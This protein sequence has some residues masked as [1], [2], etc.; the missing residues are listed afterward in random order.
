[1][2][3]DHAH[4]HDHAHE[5]HITP[6]KDYVMTFLALLVLMVLT[7][8]AAKFNFGAANNVIAMII[9][10]TKAT[11]VVLIFMG[12]RHNTRLTWLW[13]GLGFV[14]FLL[15]FGILADYF[16]R[17]WLPTPGWEDPAPQV[18]IERQASQAH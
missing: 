4:D 5:H 14:W 6:V 13:A 18:Q 1:M 17:E 16:S 2:T 11:M 3:A 7:I 10:I 12:V 15:M 8:V 9:A